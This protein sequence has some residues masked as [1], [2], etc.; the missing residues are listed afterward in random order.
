MTSYIT[1]QVVVT[2][3]EMVVGKFSDTHFS[4]CISAKP[5][6]LD[7]DFNI[8][9]PMPEGLDK[10][11]ETLETDQ[12]L[13]LLQRIEKG[14]PESGIELERMKHS[15]PYVMQRGQ[16]RLDLLKATGY[17][18]WYDWSLE[19]WGTKWYACNTAILKHEGGYLE[20]CFDTIWKSPVPIFE[21]LAAMWPD[22]TFEITATD[23][24]QEIV[25][26]QSYNRKDEQE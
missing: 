9:T 2:G 3:E 23:A 7:F 16:H 5:S 14:D 6:Q 15:S 19:H 4:Q 21:K 25:W 8:I 24:T 11:I 20:F 13:K 10:A 1:N 22:L 12:A 18:S 26:R 17:S